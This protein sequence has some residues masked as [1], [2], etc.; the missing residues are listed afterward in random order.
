MIN[1]HRKIIAWNLLAIFTFSNIIPIN[2]LAVSS[3]PSQPEVETFQPI[4]A[5]GLVNK[6]TGDFS[7]NLPLLSV[8]G[9][10]G[11][12]PL[13]LIY[14]AGA[15]MYQE[16][17]W[18]GL[19]WNL[20]PGV[21]KRHLNGVPDEFNGDLVTHY[22][23]EKEQTRTTNTL[24]AEISGSAGSSA[25]LTGSIGGSYSW[26]DDNYKGKGFSVG[27]QL[28]GG[29]FA[30]V[31]SVKPSLGINNSVSLSSFDG[32][33]SSFGVS[34]GLEV[35]KG[36][37]AGASLSSGIN[38]TYNSKSG[39][40]GRSFYSTV[41]RSFTHL[42]KKGRQAKGRMKRRVARAGSYDKMNAE[43]K[44]AHIK[45]FGIIILRRNNPSETVTLGS[46][47][48]TNDN[49]TSSIAPYGMAR[50]GKTRTW[51]LEL[52]VDIGLVKKL[53]NLS[54]SASY[55]NTRSESS[56]V[57]KEQHLNSYGYLNLGNYYNNGAMDYAT[58]NRAPLGL[59]VPHISYPK[60]AQDGFVAN[61]Q[62]VSGF[63]QA[64][65][66]DIG[67][68]H[69]TES[70]GEIEHKSDELGVSLSLADGGI[71][72][73]YNTYINSKTKT[74]IGGWDNAL[75]T[76]FDSRF[77]QTLSD[78]DY[79]EAYSF[80][81][82]GELT[83]RDQL[84]PTD[85]FLNTKVLTFDL[86]KDDIS[87]DY[88]DKN[89]FELR[90]TAPT[91]EIKKERTSRN[92]YFDPITFGEYNNIREAYGT[93]KVSHL[94][95]KNTHPDELPIAA[96]ENLNDYVANAVN[97]FP[98]HFKEIQV[99]N[100][101]GEL[102]EYGIPV[103]NN[104]SREITFSSNPLDV[105]TKVRDR[106]KLGDSKEGLEKSY[107]GSSFENYAN[108]YL[109]TAI[110][111][112]DYVDIT[113]NGP[114]E[115]D[116]GFWVK[117]NY[118]K[119]HDDFLWGSPSL[120]KANYIP[121]NASNNQD[122]YGSY[123]S[124]SKKLY[125]LNSV[126]TK[127]H[128]AKFKISNRA[129]SQ[130]GGMSL[131]KLDRV[132]LYNKEGDTPLK[133]VHFKYDYSL[134]PGGGNPA[135][136]TP[137]GKLTLKKLY[138]TYRN[139]LK[140]RLTPYTFDYA[141]NP[142][143]K[144]GNFDA[145][146][147]YNEENATGPYVDQVPFTKQMDNATTKE[148]RDLNASSWNLSTI[149]LPSKGTIEVD[150][151]MDDYQWVQNKKSMQMHEIIGLATTSQ[152][153]PEDVSEDGNIE[154]KYRIFFKFHLDDYTLINDD[155][156]KSLVD[157][158][159]MLYFRT[160]MY[161]KKDNYDYAKGYAPVAGSYG[162][163]DDAGTKIGYIDIE[164]T[165][166]HSSRMHKRVADH[167]STINVHP[168][169]AEV[170]KQLQHYRSDLEYVVSK[171]QKKKELWKELKKG[172]ERMALDKGFGNKYDVSNDFYPSYIRL[173]TANKAKY[174]G[175]HRVKS[176]KIT[177]QAND[178][179][180][181]A[182][183]YGQVY[184]YL[185]RAGNSSGV[186]GSEPFAAKEESPFKQPMF[187][188][189]VFDYD[190]KSF[191]DEELYTDYCL[192]E[193]FFSSAS[194][195]YARIL[196]E[197]VSFDASGSIIEIDE[198]VADGV[199]EEEYYTSKDFPVIY[200]YRLND[201][202]ASFKR[203][204]WAPPLVSYYKKHNSFGYSQ[205]LTVEV[206]DMSGKLKAVGKYPYFNDVTSSEFNVIRPVYKEIHKYRQD[207]SNRIDSK[208]FDDS[209][210]VDK[211]D[212][213]VDVETAI[214]VEQNR[215]FTK[216]HDVKARFKFVGF[217][218]IPISFQYTNTQELDNAQTISA[219]KVI[220]RN[221]ILESKEIIVEG[222]SSLE[223]DMKYSLRTGTVTE[224]K[225]TDQ[226]GVDNKVI[227]D[228]AVEHYPQT[229]GKYLYDNLKF[230]SGNINASGIISLTVNGRSDTYLKK[231]DKLLITKS[232]NDHVIGYIDHVNTTSSTSNT[233]EGDI[234]II[235]YTGNPITSVVFSNIKVIDPANTNQLT[236][237]SYVKVLRGDK[238]LS[239]KAT[240]FKDT[241][242]DNGFEEEEIEN[243]GFSVF[244][245]GEYENG[246][247]GI[248]RPDN[249]YAY[250]GERL[251]NN[252]DYNGVYNYSGTFPDFDFDDI[253]NNT[254]WISPIQSSKY[255]PYGYGIESED[256][257][258]IKSSAFYDYNK[259]L[260]TISAQNAAYKEIAFD[261]F[262][263]YP[264]GEINI[265]HGHVIWKM[266]DG[267]GPPIYD[268]LN[269]SVSNEASHTGHKS[270]KFHL[271]PI[272]STA[273]FEFSTEV[274]G[275]S[276][277][278]KG[279]EFEKGKKYIIQYWEKPSS[280]VP[281]M[282]FHVSNPHVLTLQNQIKVGDWVRKEYVLKTD[283]ISDELTMKFHNPIDMEGV[284][285]IDDFR[286]TPFN[287]ASK[288]FVYDSHTFNLMAILDQNH[289]ASI[290]QYDEQGN[291]VI[292]KKE[293]VNGVKSISSKRSN[294]QR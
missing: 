105:G 291:L 134:C 111:S 36:T 14:S 240:T 24:S 90:N 21:V 104:E 236:L 3:G 110:Y 122:Q 75:L 8:P 262:E 227:S 50:T 220:A 168:F 207:S 85:I 266:I 251:Y 1:S 38:W 49:V 124:G 167:G 193:P 84:N 139:N 147:T 77:Q 214:A 16:A 263:D 204:S 246:Q 53:L 41:G 267:G 56:P 143:F 61:G 277:G 94:Y 96:S 114:T 187:Y 247:K 28:G 284:I 166:V 17:S 170:L 80:L 279:W 58:H 32:I 219:T 51:G 33:T 289:F 215:T 255:S 223:K 54:A 239:A 154:N 233:W 123:Q 12:Y 119:V 5:S 115:D 66:N 97:Y 138:T 135:T 189:S 293:T 281:S 242:L 290:Y 183:S 198:R 222:I 200:E 23:Y 121:G 48:T 101:G 118:S 100:V 87:G 199:V 2:L 132:E 213:G 55:T 67:L 287:S 153:D 237:N 249:V 275:Q 60:Y 188:S 45:D 52:G 95:L 98:H 191:N 69:Q 272:P 202:V 164:P 133:T 6:Y 243:Y 216:I 185:D 241:W 128:I 19:G 274:I 195:G 26:I 59:T 42:N 270:L 116:F 137:L 278:T 211:K 93:N 292:S 268:N 64:K 149:T 79:Y 22:N 81:S 169:Q 144:F 253:S 35:I 261:A 31:K 112:P 206:N 159:D 126:E 224:V 282:P 234:G 161:Y 192:A 155:Y 175:G 271:S 146:G 250:N 176:V 160:W 30:K 86:D 73:S 125:Y 158:I 11:S 165:E 156:M 72:A 179:G 37:F 151:E 83:F 248:L 269:V 228:L 117:F 163:I 181:E 174:G 226:Y 254:D 256:L 152:L 209:G 43:D 288:A 103:Y 57:K 99:Y 273:D 44:K 172:F 197:K 74:K 232:S 229:R 145:W 18:V 173:N 71:V 88:D 140:G 39:Y 29:V 107:R 34:F 260:L 230:S 129:D 221:G 265:N 46:S 235:D 89:L 182:A 212:L 177:D 178:L 4:G 82:T 47:F 283:A 141:H 259:S 286:I 13:N 194:V 20:N 201:P 210:S 157:G 196:E 130:S 25:G 257:R 27:Y 162:F 10:N 203:P 205:G 258:E 136:A 62:G 76:N 63:F 285:Y 180:L 65:R 109:L 9:P 68:L 238:V 91:F 108:A 70:S 7:Y 190:D 106:L 92:Q 171:K 113:N 276:E 78:D 218:P 148:E 294:I 127:T 15:G 280:D 225:F 150:Y 231:G 186:T 208:V 244:P 252:T 245:T 217:V 102:Y 120:E 142:N 40:R 264:L 131:Q 184:H